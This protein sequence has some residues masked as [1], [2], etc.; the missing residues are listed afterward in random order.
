ML[1]AQKYQ[2]VCPVELSALSLELSDN[3]QSKNRVS[4]ADFHYPAYC[5]L[6][7]PYC[8]LYALSPQSFSLS[9]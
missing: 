2:S 4:M 1:K 9:P 5:L 3:F 6:P 8:L 7:T